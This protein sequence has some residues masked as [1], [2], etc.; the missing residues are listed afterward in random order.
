MYNYIVYFILILVV[1]KYLLQTFFKQGKLQFCGTDPSLEVNRL[2]AR[3]ILT[4]W[5]FC[6]TLNVLSIPHSPL[7]PLN[8]TAW[9]LSDFNVTKNV[10]KLF[11]IYLFLTNLS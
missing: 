8:I 1:K 6:D 10:S 11:I 2:M 3:Y 9:Q 4:L 5:E 7:W